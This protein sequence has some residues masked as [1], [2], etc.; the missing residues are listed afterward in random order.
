MSRPFRSNV[1]VGKHVCLVDCNDYGAILDC[2]GGDVPAQRGTDFG[3]RKRTTVISQSYSL[4]FHAAR[5]Q[6]HQ[7]GPRLQS[8]PLKVYLIVAHA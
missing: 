8:K 7:Y 5:E 3:I 2:S 6:N 4:L 1:L